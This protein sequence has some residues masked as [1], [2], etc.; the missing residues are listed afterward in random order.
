MSGGQ[1]VNKKYSHKES[2]LLLMQYYIFHTINLAR[3]FAIRLN[4]CFKPFNDASHGAV[5]IDI[6]RFSSFSLWRPAKI[7]KQVNIG[8]A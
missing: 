1:A 5:A 8:G 3:Q 7:P 4:S 6:K 2:G